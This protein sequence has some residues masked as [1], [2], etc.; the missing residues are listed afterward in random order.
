MA[1]QRWGVTIPLMGVT[2]AEHRRYI[3]EIAELGFTDVWSSEA[4]AHDAFTPLALTAAWTPDLRLGQA[5]IPVYTRGPALLAQSIASLCEAAPGRVAVGIGTSSNVI[6]QRWNDIP[7]EQPY[8]RTRDTIRF[9]RAALN[10][11]KVTEEYET[12]RVDGFR[13]G[14]RV[15][16]QPPILVGALREGMLRL[17][18]READGAIVNWLSA[19]DVRTVAPIVGEGKEVAARIFVMPSEDRAAV[20]QLGT[21][22][23]AEYLNVP[24]YAAFHEWIGRGEALRD[25]WAAWREGDRKRATAS[26]PDEVIDDLIVH[27]S[28]EQCAAHVRRYA[29]NGV[30]TP[31]PMI[32][33]GPE[34]TMRVVRAMAPGA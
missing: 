31:A 21:R 12:F 32:L 18:G 17:A 11:E 6:V 13:L 34:D 8:Q 1:E 33:A 4:G 9:L 24:V 22:L 30:T 19:E 15:A 5:V 29:A 7:F 27:G 28:P 2:L 3:E 10:G 16:E 23:I 20:R 14:V 25:M 26:I